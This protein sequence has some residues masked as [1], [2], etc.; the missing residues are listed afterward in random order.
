MEPKVKNRKNYKKPQIGQVN[1][2]IE[3]AVLQACK[4]DAGQPGRAGK[5]CDRAPCR[6]GTYGS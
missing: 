4:T 5:T 1:L 3:E 6:T 2:I